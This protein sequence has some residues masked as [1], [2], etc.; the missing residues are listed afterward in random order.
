MKLMI[1]SPCHG[2]KV[3]NL[4][5]DSLIKTCKILTESNIDHE[6]FLPTTGSILSKERNEL[7]QYFMESDCT[8][9]LC[10]DSDLAWTPE[11]VLNMINHDREFIAGVYPAR[12]NNGTKQYIFN[13]ELNPNG[14]LKCEDSLLKMLHVPAG[15]MLIKR[16]VIEK[17]RTYYPELKYK[18]DNGIRNVDEAYAFFNTE[19][20]DGHFWGEDFI[21]CRRVIDAGIEIWCEPK[22]HFVHAGIPGGIYEILTNKNEQFSYTVDE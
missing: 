22:I 12:T 5:V 3:E 6:V 8:H 10:V 16:E 11:S 21:F 17:L 14:S 13:P 4:F 18:N 20:I 15:F 2:G 7:L 1:V 19:L 9:V